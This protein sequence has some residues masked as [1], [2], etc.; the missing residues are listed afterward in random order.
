MR[1]S[2][3]P[4]ILILSITTQAAAQMQTVGEDFG[5]T[6]LEKHGDSPVSSDEINNLWNWGSY[7]RGYQ[8]INGQIQPILASTEIYYPLFMTN[9]TP[10]YING[11]AAMDERNYIRQ[12]FLS[13]EF[14]GDPW[15]FAQMTE[16]PVV[17]FYPA[18]TKGSI[19]H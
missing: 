16:R 18:N 7:P 6:W 3:L 1:C 14:V 5:K 19:L 10:V 13:Q 4:A 2:F 17:V 12:D 8:E 15:L 9:S 11:T